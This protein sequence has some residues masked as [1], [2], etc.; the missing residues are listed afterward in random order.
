VDKTTL[1]EDNIKNGKKLIESLDKTEFKVKAALWFYLV[2]SNEW[3][4]MIASPF[5]DKHGTKEAYNFV[6]EELIKLS[7]HLELGLK[8]ISI[9][10]PKHKLI[11]LLKRAIHT[12]SE[13]SGIRF[14]SNVIDN[15]LIDDAYIYRM[16]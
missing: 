13:I 11:N 12:G 3:R 4:L 10:S 5:E 16:Q 8:D 15:V 7:I 9:V 2:D 14:T 6:R 1:V